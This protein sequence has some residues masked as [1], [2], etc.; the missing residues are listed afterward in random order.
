MRDSEEL[1]CEGGAQFA[2]KAELK[3]RPFLFLLLLISISLCI[4]GLSLRIIEE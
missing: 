4:F 3:E 1:Y 2:V